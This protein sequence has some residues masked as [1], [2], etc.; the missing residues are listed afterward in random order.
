[1]QAAP[2][3]LRPPM[4]RWTSFEYEMHDDVFFH[5][6]FISLDTDQWT[7]WLPVLIVA[8][9]PRDQTGSAIPRCQAVLL[10]LSGTLDITPLAFCQ[11]DFAAAVLI[12]I[13]AHTVSLL[14]PGRGTW[15]SKPAL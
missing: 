4:H 5:L 1:M 15:D 14:D 11:T 3:Y 7:V 9:W 12:I 10:A 2:P 8:S 6:S 13:V